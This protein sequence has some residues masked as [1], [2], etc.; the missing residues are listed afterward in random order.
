M[1]KQVINILWFKKDLRL[2]DHLPLKSSLEEDLPLIL[3]YIFEPSLQTYPDWAL[4]HWQFVYHSILSL[5]KT[6]KK[7]NT[8]VNIF[9]AEVKDV[10]EYLQEDFVIKQ[11]F[12]HQETGVKLTYDRDIFL[13]NYFKEKGIIWQ[14]YQNN[15][16]IRGLKERKIWDKAW[17]ETMESPQAKTNLEK[18]QSMEVDIPLVLNFREKLKRDIA[19]YPKTFQPAG[20]YY[21]RKYLKSFIE[22]RGK[23]YLQSIFKLNESREHCSRLSP[24]LTW[25]NL[26]TRQ[27]YQFYKK[28]LAKSS[29]KKNLDAFRSR[30]QWRCH[31]TQRFEMEERM[32]FENLNTAYDSLLLQ[33]RNPK[34]IQAWENAQTGF[35]IIDAAMTCVKETG[36][37][38]FRARAMLVSFLTHLLWQP[39]RSGVHFLAKQFLDYEVG[40][41]FSQFQMQAGVQGINTIRVYNP[42]KQSREND[43][44]AQ[45]IKKWL[46]HL[47]KIPHG[48]VHEPWKMTSIEQSFYNC[49]IGQDYP[50]PIIEEKIARKHATE[51]LWGLKKNPEVKEEVK[52]ILKKHVK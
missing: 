39:W 19:E 28:N 43:S 44:E 41:H 16:I 32:E 30:L 51:V 14:E 1:E 11:V 2:Q 4:R 17:V 36:Y 37:L 31:F 18:L 24:Y 34:F 35:P 10:F 52:R 23:G 50:K 8:Q 49:K 42:I 38:N 25:G 6:L 12:S 29:Y 7:Y 9:Y 46:P 27:V 26:S 40:I 3:I 47:S 13:Q 20:E 33:T 15:G 48:L 22:I 45:F 21:A 5:N